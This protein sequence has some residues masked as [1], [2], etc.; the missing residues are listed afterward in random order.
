MRADF[1]VEGRKT[2]QIEF[3]LIGLSVN[4][5]DMLGTKGSDHVFSF[6]PLDFSFS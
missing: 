3:V 2:L 6:S 4:D 5:C 1:G